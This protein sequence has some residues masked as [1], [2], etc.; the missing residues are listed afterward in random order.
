MQ[1][2]GAY[3]TKVDRRSGVSVGAPTLPASS[4]TVS[5]EAST[6]LS[7]GQIGHLSSGQ[8]GQFDGQSGQGYTKKM[9][10]RAILTQY[11]QE[12]PEAAKLSTRALAEASGVSKSTVANVMK[13]LHGRAETND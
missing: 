3:R 10:A 1:Q 7:S 13:E 8:S 6:L 9:D 12:N 5:T 11:L 4:S 2:Y